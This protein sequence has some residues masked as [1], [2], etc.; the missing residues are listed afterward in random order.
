MAESERAAA[1]AEREDDAVLQAAL[2]DGRAEVTQ[3]TETSYRGIRRYRTER[4]GG[5]K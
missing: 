5:D 3:I 4:S 1:I 2:D